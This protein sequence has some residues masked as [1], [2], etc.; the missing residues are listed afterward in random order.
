LPFGGS[1]QL[2]TPCAQLDN[3]APLFGRADEVIE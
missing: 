2:K 1:A 3:L